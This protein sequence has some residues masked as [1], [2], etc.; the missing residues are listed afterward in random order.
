MKDTHMIYT[1]F[2]HL[3]SRIHA[4]FKTRNGVWRVNNEW[5]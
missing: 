1:I 5:P 2:T 4:G 3:L